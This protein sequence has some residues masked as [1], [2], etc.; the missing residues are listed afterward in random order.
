MTTQ[1]TK[2]K[3]TGRSEEQLYSVKMAVAL[4]EFRATSM[5]VLT[6]SGEQE[7]GTHTE[8]AKSKRIVGR[9]VRCNKQYHHYRRGSRV[10]SQSLLSLL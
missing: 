8:N 1:S 7:D 3:G 2:E 9:K 6:S 4:T 5:C 10:V